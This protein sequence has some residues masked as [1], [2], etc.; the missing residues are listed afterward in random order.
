MAPQ[1]AIMGSFQ[2][3]EQ[4]MDVSWENKDSSISM[5]DEE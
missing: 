4:N 3:S 1:Q 2:I 5:T